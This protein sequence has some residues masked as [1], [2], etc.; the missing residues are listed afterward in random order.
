MSCDVADH[1]AVVYGEISHTLKEG[2]LG[3]VPLLEICGDARI[4]WTIGGI[5]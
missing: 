3:M 5:G 2:L 1:I 4:G